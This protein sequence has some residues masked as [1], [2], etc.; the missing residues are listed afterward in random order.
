M[1][2]GG[3][4]SHSDEKKVDRKEHEDRRQTAPR[5]SEA[6]IVGQVVREAV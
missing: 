4:P 5:S 3:S 6:P 1:T 2:N